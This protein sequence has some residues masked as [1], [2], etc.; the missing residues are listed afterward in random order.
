MY[1]S[2]IKHKKEINN[3]ELNELQDLLQ[4]WKQEWINIWDKPTET[5]RIAVAASTWS[6]LILDMSGL[7]TSESMSAE[8]KNSQVEEFAKRQK[9]YFPQ[10][11]QFSLNLP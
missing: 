10:L 9:R 1:L 3:F 8:F 2:L 4:A 11:K 6:Q 7:L 5:A